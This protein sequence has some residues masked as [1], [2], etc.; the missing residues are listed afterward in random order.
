MSYELL[1]QFATD[2]S[3]PAPTILKVGALMVAVGML[4]AFTFADGGILGKKRKVAASVAA[5]AVEVAGFAL[6]FVGLLQESRAPKAPFPYAQIKTDLQE[7]YYVDDLYTA[8]D[9]SILL[10]SDNAK[11]EQLDITKAVDGA[12][13]ELKVRY[14]D[15]LVPVGF[16]YDSET[17]RPKLVELAEKPA[18]P[19]ISQIEKLH[20]H[21]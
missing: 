19:G 15:V 7:N 9:P 2:A 12:V 11:I 1:R 10:S 13:V 18:S 3:A 20:S 21:D 5:I 8:Q 6:V 16:T 14:K 17:K 4:V